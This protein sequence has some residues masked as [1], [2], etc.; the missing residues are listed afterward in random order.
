MQHIP[1]ILS[2]V[3]LN[4][5]AQIFIRQGMLKLGERFFQYGTNLEYGFIRIYQYVFVVGNVQLWHK[6]YF[7]DDCPV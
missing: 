3:F 4:A 7:M 2:S 5:L 1:L 6:H